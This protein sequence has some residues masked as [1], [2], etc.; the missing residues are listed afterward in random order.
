MFASLASLS[1]GCQASIPLGFHDKCPISVSFVS[2]NGGDRFLLDAVQALFASLQEQAEI[3]AQSKSSNN[4]ISKEASAEMAKEKRAIG[5][6]T[7]AIKLNG[8]CATYFSNRAA[9]YLELGSFIQAE[10]DCT[11][12]IE[13]DKKNV[14]AYFRRGTAREMLGYYNQAIEG[15]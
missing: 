5:F 4:A 1:G 13:L 8:N 14:K 2:R 9:A 7:E 12:A 15:E 10:A 6:Y 11:K 3:A